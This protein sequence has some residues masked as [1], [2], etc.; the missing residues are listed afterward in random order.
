MGHPTPDWL[1]RGDKHSTIHLQAA[2][3]KQNKMFWSASVVYKTIIHLGSAVIV[4]DIYIHLHFG[5]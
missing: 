4:V 3:E 1:T 5:A 2:E